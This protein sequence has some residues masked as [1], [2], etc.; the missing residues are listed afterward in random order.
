MNPFHANN[1][2]AKHIKSTQVLHNESF[3]CVSFVMNIV[4]SMNF[5]LGYTIVIYNLQR[6]FGLVVYYTGNRTLTFVYF[7]FKYYP[8]GTS[9]C[10]CDSQIVFIPKCILKTTGKCLFQ[11]VRNELFFLECLVPFLYMGSIVAQ[12]SF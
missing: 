12:N 10:F 11:S 2:L 1:G 6:T 4:K 3:I 9:N 8:R 5:A 7:T